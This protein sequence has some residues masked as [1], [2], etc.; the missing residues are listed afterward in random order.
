MALKQAVL[1]E[2]EHVEC[3]PEMI[4][5]AVVDE[6]VDVHLIRKYFTYDGYAWLLVEQVLEH[7]QKKM[8]WICNVCHRNRQGLHLHVNPVYSG[9]IL[10]VLAYRSS[11]RPR[12]GF[13]VHVML[14]PSRT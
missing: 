4:T 12:T 10:P 3:R 7:K 6:N 14:H 1:I 2:E 5:N 9:S 8:T 11:Q 13:V